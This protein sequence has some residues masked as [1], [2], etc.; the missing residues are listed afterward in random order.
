MD[1]HTDR[2]ALAVSNRLREHR[3][4]LGLT[5][6]QA[7]AELARLAGRELSIDGNA[8]S[9]HERGKVRPTAYHQALYSRLYGVSVEQLWPVAVDRARPDASTAGHLA[10][11]VHVLRIADD[12]EPTGTLVAASEDLLTL[13]ERLTDTA[14]LADRQDV[15]RVAAE[16]AMNHWWLLVDAGRD[17]SAAHD[18]AMALAVEWG[19]TPLV[20]HLLGWRAG[21]AMSQGDLRTAVRLA[22]RSRLPQWGMSPGGVAWATAYEARAHVLAGD[23]EAPRALDIARV[24]YERVDPADEPPWLYWMSGHVLTLDR[25][26]VQ[27]L[28]EV[29]DTVPAIESG[30]P[31]GTG[32]TSP[33]PAP[34]PA[35]SRRRRR[36]R[37]KRPG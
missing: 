8:V 27:L 9:R 7:A 32:R 13:A 35:T 14:R 31:P 16:A 22:R 21:L 4:R 12:T 3:L 29:L 33:Q 36:T 6:E 20:G 19:L 17:S 18:R 24:A 11:L 15:G 37:S 23:L 2:D 34:G 30:T 10:A 26:D 28:A 25:L 5:Q 1:E